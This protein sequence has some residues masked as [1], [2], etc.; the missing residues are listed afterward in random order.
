MAKS[1]QPASDPPSQPPPEGRRLESWKEI[2]AYLKRDLRTVQRW[3]RRESLPIHRHLH[4]KRSSVYVYTSEL[5]AWRNNGRPHLEPEEPFHCEPVRTRL[6]RQR[7]V[8]VLVAT[9]AVAT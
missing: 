3:E 5:D 2:A 4:D 1:S 9:T 6:P 7:L 8:A